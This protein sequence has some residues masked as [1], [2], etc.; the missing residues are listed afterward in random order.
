MIDNWTALDRI[1]HAERETPFCV[2]GQ[3]MVPEARPGAIWLECVSLK[4]PNGSRMGRLLSLLAAG[5][6]TRRLIVDLVEDA[7]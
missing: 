4:G 2:C 6:H 1:E 7:A 3:Q 5:G